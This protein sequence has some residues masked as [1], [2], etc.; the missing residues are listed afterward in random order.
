MPQVVL[1]WEASPTLEVSYTVYRA[2]G[3]NGP[4]TAV[5]TGVS[6]LTWTDTNVSDGSQYFYYVEAVLNGISSVPSVGISVTVPEI[7]QPP[8]NLTGVAQA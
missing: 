2:G 4:Y 1:S 6:D 7:P 3:L 5:A 8:S